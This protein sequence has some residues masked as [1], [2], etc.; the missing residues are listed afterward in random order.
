M[1]FCPLVHALLRCLGA[2]LLMNHSAPTT[3][4][5]NNKLNLLNKK[6]KI[7]KEK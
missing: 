5:N 7:Q 2:G 6:K 1:S 3:N 4:N